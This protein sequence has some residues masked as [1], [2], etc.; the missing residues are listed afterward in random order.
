[1]TDLPSDDALDAVLTGF[2]LELQPPPPAASA[3]EMFAA[4]KAL[5][6]SLPPPPE[7]IRAT[8]EQLALMKLML[9]KAEPRAPWEPWPPLSSVPVHLVENVEESTPWLREW[10]APY[11]EVPFPVIWP[12]GFGPFMP[13]RK[14]LM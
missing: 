13:E 6:S 5:Y 12:D 4:I 7:P 10:A 3:E 11:C 1:M 2:M 8:R 9:P 14:D